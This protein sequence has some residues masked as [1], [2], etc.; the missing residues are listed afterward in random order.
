MTSLRETTFPRGGAIIPYGGGPHAD[1]GDDD[2]DVDDAS[3]PEGVQVPRMSGRERRGVPPLRLIE[4]MTAASE[5]RDGGAPSSY[6]EALS[7][8]QSVGWKK[9]FAIEVKSLNDNKVYTA[10][11]KP[12]GQKVVRAK[13]VLRRKLLPGGKLDKLKAR[14]VAKGFTQREELDYEETFSPTLR[15]ESVRLMVAGAAAGNM[16]T[17]KMDVTTTFLYAS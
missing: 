7:G 9:A 5:A 16:H 13:W 14:I 3:E 1:D 11:D 17:H 12:S 8:P 6:E 10:V 15:F 4:I 2:G